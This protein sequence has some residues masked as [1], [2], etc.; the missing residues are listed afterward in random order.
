[1]PD[2]EISVVIRTFNEE[3]Y[4]PALLEALNHQS[5]NDFETIVVDSGSLDRT[6]EIAAQKADQLL[7]IQ[8]HDFTFGHSLNVGIL[9]ASGKY[10][11]IVSAHTL[12]ASDQWLVK[13][14]EPMHNNRTAMVYGRQLGGDASKFSEIQDMRRTFGSR[15]EILQ[16]PKFFANNANSAIRKDLW[17]QHPFD[18]S[19]PGLEDIEWAKYWMERNY[20]VVY[21]PAAALYHIHE[22]NWRQVRRRFYR[23]AIAAR[24]IGIKNLKHAGL[25]LP[26][27]TIYT[28]LDLGSGCFTFNKSRQKTRKYFD[29]ARE[30]MLFRIN[31]TIG[32]VKGLLD[33]NA[34]ENQTARQNIY[35][36]RTCKAVVIHG[37]GRA[38]LDEVEVPEVKPGD[39]MIRVAYVSICATDLEILDG[40][41]GYY[42]DGIAKY[43]IVPGHEFS[44]RV[45]AFG[46]NVSHLQEG[47]PVVVECI[48]SCGVCEACK[49]QNWIACQSRTELGVIGHN[50]G[51]SELVVVPGHFVHRLPVD[52]DLRKASLCE[53]MAVVLK[54][55]R[56][57]ERA[58]QSASDSQRCAVVGAGPLGNLCAQ[59]LALR[60]H[61]V[62][63][64]DRNPRR[65]EYLSDLKI[66]VANDLNQLHKYNVLVEVTGDPDALDGILHNSPAGATILLL[67]LPYA[68]RQFTFEKIVAFDK[69]VVGS[70]GSSAKDFADAIALL[71]QLETASFFEKVLPLSDFTNAWELARSQ[72]YL[73]VIFDVSGQN[74]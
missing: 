73:K 7:R 35:F 56:R 71:P 50:G 20:Q 51:Y 41:L 28:L 32:T 15:R 8:S 6:R 38:S 1:M 22:E 68:H 37:A 2:P 67:G 9:M 63:V 21:E 14:V 60:G 46:P 16:P 36:D 59:T 29:F 13:L 64:F 66:S 69:T 4:L 47:D 43:P 24:R 3:K 5:L 39:V 11:V 54:G 48:Q 12:P 52:F 19:L 33:G 27:E 55:I 58:L 74:F 42:K 34:L 62:T 25:T 49:R 53:P 30:A 26:I 31:K 65:L 70:V 57:L 17:Q 40:T 61:R 45:V 44:G 72:K 10:I 23:E 18:E